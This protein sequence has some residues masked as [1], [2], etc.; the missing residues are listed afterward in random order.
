MDVSLPAVVL[1]SL[2]CGW[3]LQTFPW[4]C[5]IVCQCEG[6]C[7]LGGAGAI[8]VGV[9]EDGLSSEAEEQSE[10]FLWASGWRS[11]LVLCKSDEITGSL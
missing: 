5:C 7:L 4:G 10:Q 11:G 1:R 3:A 6:S 8:R 9:R 2:G